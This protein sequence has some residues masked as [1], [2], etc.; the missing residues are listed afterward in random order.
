MVSMPTLHH[1][2]NINFHCFGLQGIAVFKFYKIGKTLF[3]HWPYR[4]LCSFSKKQQHGVSGNVAITT[5]PGSFIATITHIHRVQG[6]LPSGLHHQQNVFSLFIENR[7]AYMVTIY[8]ASSEFRS[9]IRSRIS[10]LE[11]KDRKQPQRTYYSYL[12]CVG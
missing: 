8:V 10:S 9:L 6:T 4:C 11:R 5:F 1:Y 12:E 7:T 3:K 2:I